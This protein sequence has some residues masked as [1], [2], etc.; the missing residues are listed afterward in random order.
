MIDH[1][2][3]IRRAVADIVYAYRQILGEN[4]HPL[5]LR[6]FAVA[7]NQILADLGEGVSYQT[8]KNWEDRAHL[9]HLY[10]MIYISINAPNDWRRDFAVDILSA[11]RPNLYQPVSDIGH[12]ALDRSLTDTGPLKPRYDNRFLRR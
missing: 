3:P 8:I 4:G 1:T 5:S 6:D 7:L 11:L 9:P 12:W 2:L 10:Y